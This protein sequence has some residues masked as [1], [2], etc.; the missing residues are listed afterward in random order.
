[1]VLYVNLK[2]TGSLIRFLK[3]KESKMMK[4]ATE[5]PFH[6]CLNESYSDYFICQ[7]HP[8]FGARRDGVSIS[9]TSD[10]LCYHCVSNIFVNFY[11][12][13]MMKYSNFL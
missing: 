4:A 11:L 3:G 10:L 6:Y 9:E 2:K 7:D 13:C 12:I 5:S 8:S 1:M